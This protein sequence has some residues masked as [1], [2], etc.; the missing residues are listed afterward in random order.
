MDERTISRRNLFGIGLGRL[1]PDLPDEG[2]RRAT[3]VEE[4][5]WGAVDYGPLALALRPAAAELADFCAP[6]AGMRL[7]DVGAGDGNLAKLCGDRGADVV[8]LDR[9]AGMVARGR[10]RVPGAEWHNSDLRDMP[11]E[12]GAFDCTASA[13]GAIYTG[14]TAAVARELFRVTRPGGLVAMANWS[15]IG[16]VAE[17]M[18][19]LW[20]AGAYPGLRAR[21]S[22]WGR[23]ETVYREFMPYS[24][25]Y[26]VLERE[27]TLPTGTAEGYWDL[28]AGSYGP[29]AGRL[30]RLAPNEATALRSQVVRIARAHRVAGGVSATYVIAY[31]RAA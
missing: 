20:H 2:P 19:A 10:E 11:F 14:P 18:S 24:S 26:D 17:T 4:D 21:P 28:L 12:A 8:A 25:D 31:G 9:S 29:L 6:A 1:L 22:T 13:F 5:V 7:L 15:S 30:R 3:A 23:F 27:L 16:L